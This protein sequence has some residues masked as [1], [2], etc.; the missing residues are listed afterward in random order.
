MPLALPAESVPEFIKP[1]ADRLR[2]RICAWVEKCMPTLRNAQPDLPDELNDRQQDGAEILLA[3]AE[4]AGGP[5]VDKTRKA[6]VDLYTDGTADDQSIHVKLLGDIQAIFGEKSLDR[7]FSEELV[8]TLAEIETSPWAEWKNQKPMTP[9][10]LARQ[11]KEFEVYPRTIR[12]NDDQKKGYER[13]ECT[14]K[15]RQR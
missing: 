11:L 4:S 1:E 13:V 9:T 5:W 8:K 3:V 12:I 6:L 7:I 15:L 10:Q 2:D 14:P